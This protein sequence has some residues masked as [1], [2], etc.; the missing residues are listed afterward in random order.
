MTASR[1]VTSMRGWRV[2]ARAAAM[3]WASGCEATRVLERIA[4]RHQ[5][6]H[7]VE[8]EPLHRQQARGE[9]RL[10]RR[11]ER[12]AEQADAHAGRMRRKRNSQ[13]FG[14]LRRRRRGRGLSTVCDNSGRSRA[15]PR[16]PGGEADGRQRHGRV[17]PVP[18]T[19]YL[20][21]AELLEPDRSARVEAAGR[22]ADLGAE[23]ELAAIGELRRGVVQHDRRID[24]ARGISRPPPGR[25]SRSRRCDASHSARHGR[26]P[27]RRRRPPS[28]R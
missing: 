7:A 18:R 8:V 25:P 26:S 10:M 28:P 16:S 2:S 15:G 9:M 12:A 23:A 27:R 19:R 13:A 3:R 22:D 24:F 11:I 17:C 14:W 6:P 20:K 4:R 1:P 21:R 5:P